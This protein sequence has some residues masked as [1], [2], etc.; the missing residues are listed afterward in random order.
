M[1][2]IVKYGESHETTTTIPF[3]LFYILIKGT[4]VNWPCHS[5]I[6]KLLEITS[7]VPE[8]DTYYIES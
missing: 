2:G 3:N 7:L 1:G 4:I 5:L 6:G 8:L